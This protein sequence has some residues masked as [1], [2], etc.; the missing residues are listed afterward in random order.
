MAMGAYF[1]SVFPIVSP[2]II[3]LVVV[4]GVSFIHTNNLKFGSYFQQ[5]FTAL[6]VLLILILIG[7]GLFLA[8]SQGLNF[9]PYS[10]RFWLGF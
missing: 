5:S 6:K 4:I 7:C 10:R 1:S 9:L 8:N 3:A 2:R